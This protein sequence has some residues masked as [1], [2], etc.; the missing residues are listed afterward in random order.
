M[1]HKKNISLKDLNAFLRKNKTVDFRTSDLQHLSSLEAYK[2]NGLEDQKESVSEQLKA[3]Q[4][5][6]RVVPHDQENL[7]K[8]LLKRGI[9]SSLQ[10]ASVPKSTFIQN[11]LKVFDGDRVLAEKVYMRALAVRKAV[12]LQYIARQ[13]RAEPHARA[14]GLA[15]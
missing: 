2:W 14:I 9:C 5:L 6:L 1:S 13:Q 4:R 12:A 3:Y 11:N 10:I 7:A 8:D 15:S